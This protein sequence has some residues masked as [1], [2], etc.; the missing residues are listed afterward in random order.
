[1]K[2][3]QESK[4]LI[5]K[6]INS[7][8]SKKFI[9]DT[10]KI[11]NATYHRLKSQTNKDLSINNISN[12]DLSN[13]DINNYINDISNNDLSKNDI[14]NTQNDISNNNISQ[15]FEQFEEEN[16]ENVSNFDIND[17]K[18][19]LNN[20][21]EFIIIKNNDIKKKLDTSVVSQKSNISKKS[22]SVKSASFSK[23]QNQPIQETILDTI[24]NCNVSNNIVELK[25]IRSHIII[26]RQYIQNFPEELK[27]IYGN[28]RLQF[29]KRL[30]C[31][32]LDQLKIVLE[33]IRISISLKS[34]SS[35]FQAV[36][37]V[38]IKGIEL[39]STNYLNYDISGLEQSLK[40]DKEFQLDLRIISSEVDLSRYLNPKSQLFIKLIRKCYMINQE[41]K[42]KK[43]INSVI[44]DQDKLDLIKNLDNNK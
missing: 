38:C 5:I 33:D 15:N 16:Q 23:K 42:I 30:F 28:N 35:N 44:N 10:H 6:D 12:N 20:E 7:G 11:S 32:S 3:S 41:N 9:M 24:Q 31:M 40:D 25:E 36:S 21:N 34:N 19:Q 22:I 2:L 18:K 37:S 17:F 43:T 13:N 8:L 39:I 14:S 29:E 26:I 4:D 27:L 1:M